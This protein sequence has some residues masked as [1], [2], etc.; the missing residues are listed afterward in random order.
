MTAV[1]RWTGLGKLVSCY[2]YIY[3]NGPRTTLAL[4]MVLVLGVG[5]IHLYLLVTDQALARGVASPAYLDVYFT[6]LFASALLAALSMATGRRP[7]WALGSLASA[8]TIMMYV[9]SRVWGLPDLPLLVRWWDYPLGT[10][11]LALAAMFL[12]L[13]FSVMTGLNVAY[14][15]RRDWHD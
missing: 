10:F 13:H 2:R 8:A 7:G 12:G 15:D 3:F 1:L 6:L 11:V 14:P 4:G 9:V 5:A